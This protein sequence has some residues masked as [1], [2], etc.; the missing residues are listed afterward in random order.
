MKYRTALLA[1]VIAC[2][3][4]GHASAAGGAAEDKRER[5]GFTTAERAEFLSEMRAMLTSV[6]GILAGIAA[7]DR[8]GIAEAARYSGNRMS[9][10]TP[11][12]VRAKLPAA[13][14]ALGGPTHLLFEEIVTRAETD[15]MADLTRLTAETLRQC[16]ACH[17]LYRVD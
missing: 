11:A 14:K 1:L 4:A 2:L 9:R 16:V 13:F 12:E 15:E 8:A 6:Q 17:A 7:E 10:A 3:T 5:L